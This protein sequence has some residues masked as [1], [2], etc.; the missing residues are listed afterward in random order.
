MQQ[1]SG[2]TNTTKSFAA[3]YAIVDTRIKGGNDVSAVV[4]VGKTTAPLGDFQNSGKTQKNYAADI[5]ADRFGQH[6]QKAHMG[7]DKRSGGELV[8][9]PRQVEA[10]EGTDFDI[11]VAEQYWIQ[12]YKSQGAKLVN[13][14]NAISKS[15]FDEIMGDANIGNIFTTKAAYGGSTPSI[16]DFKSL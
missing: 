15:K 6:V 2:F 1:A 10:F 4:Y 12:S 7:W 11:A 3:I 5:I 8:F 16:K 13:D 14:V 9:A